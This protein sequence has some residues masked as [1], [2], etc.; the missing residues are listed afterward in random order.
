MEVVGEVIAAGAEVTR[1]KPGDRVGATVMMGAY[2]QE[3][4]VHQNA[5]MAV[6]PG[7]DAGEVTALMCGFGTAHHGAQAARPAESRARRWS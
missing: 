1:F 6:P 5:V 4:K 7:A 3:V 2:A